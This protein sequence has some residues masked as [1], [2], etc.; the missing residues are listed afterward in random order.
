VSFL[1]R[2]QWFLTATSSRRRVNLYFR[3]VGDCLITQRQ[4]FRRDTVG[5]GLSA[6]GQ[7]VAAAGAAA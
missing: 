7:T 3:S 2:R 4:L 5:D 1:R 6:A